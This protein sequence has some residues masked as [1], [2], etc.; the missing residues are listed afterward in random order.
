MSTEILNLGAVG[1][2]FFFFLREFFAYLKAKKNGNGNGNVDYK[3]ELTGINNKL[4]NHL[5]DVNNKI[6]SIER[7]IINIRTDVKI[8]KESLNDIKIAIK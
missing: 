8:I 6:S 2:L 3:I 7:E 1:I 4:N 5:H